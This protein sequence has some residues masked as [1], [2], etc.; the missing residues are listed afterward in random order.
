MHGVASKR[1]QHIALTRCEA[2][3]DSGNATQ[4]A[5]LSTEMLASSIKQRL[6]NK[7]MVVGPTLTAHAW[8]GYV[9]VLKKAGMHFAMLDM[10]HGST[11]LAA[12]EE[13]CRVARLIDFPIL[14]RPEASIFHLIRK[15]VD[16]GPA[17]FVIPWTERPEQ[18]EALRDGVFTPP[19][20]RRGPGGPSIGH[21]RSID[22]AGWDE[23]EKEFC[24]VAQ[25]ESPAGIAAL[26]Q[27]VDHDW[28]D[29]T[30]LGPYDLSLNMGLCWQ[31]NHPDLL[32]AI[33][34]VFDRSAAV[35]KP[36]GTVTYDRNTS[37]YWIDRGFRFFIYGD[38]IGMIATEAGRMAR[39]VAELSGDDKPDTPATLA[40]PYSGKASG[41]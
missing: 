27:L 15:Y 19:R 38:P 18:L 12:A 11:T 21:N 37:K 1:D 8:A 5:P 10:E 28:L 26:P 36:C 40:G 16:M 2:K 29:A 33:Q 23:L 20:G 14:I 13:I 22:R 25:I 4:A 6:R 24:L 32:A 9:E 41:R 35:G 34:T 7:Q 3:P 30:M 39:E 31:P 17:G